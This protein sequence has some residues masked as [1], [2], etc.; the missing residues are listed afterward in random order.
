M[1]DDD[2]G[3]RKIPAFLRKVFLSKR[4]LRL[5]LELL[6]ASVGD[7][8]LPPWKQK[9][10]NKIDNHLQKAKSYRRKKRGDDC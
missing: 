9:L 3:S 1:S 6:R 8:E 5:I 7:E 4:E 2:I 10:I